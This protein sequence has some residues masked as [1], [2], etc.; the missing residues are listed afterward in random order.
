MFMCISY[1][2]YR[3]TDLFVVIQPVSRTQ[4]SDNLLSINQDPV[5]TN[6]LHKLPDKLP[7][8]GKLAQETFQE[9]LNRLSHAAVTGKSTRRTAKNSQVKLPL[10]PKPNSN[11]HG[12]AQEKVFIGEVDL[13]Q[14]QE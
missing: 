1:S 13:N 14:P 7:S 10:P 3:E 2:V 12:L 9:E 8:M 6:V 5:D 11:P 4:Y